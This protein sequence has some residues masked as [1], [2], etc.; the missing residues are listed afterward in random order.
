MPMPEL[1]FVF[2]HGFDA[3]AAWVHQNASDIMEGFDELPRKLRNWINYADTPEEGARAT[4]QIVDDL[5]ARRHRK[6]TTS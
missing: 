4:Y 3:P 5:L 1:E 2:I 6:S